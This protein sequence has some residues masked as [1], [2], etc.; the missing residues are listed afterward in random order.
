MFG[1][2][3]GE[4]D[5]YLMAHLC[6]RIVEMLRSGGKKPTISEFMPS[7]GREPIDSGEHPKPDAPARDRS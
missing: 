6:Y 2:I 1:P 3:G 4:R 7:W 5:D